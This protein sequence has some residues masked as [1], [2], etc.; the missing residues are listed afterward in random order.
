[1]FGLHQPAVSPTPP[2]LVM[3][4][5]N[6]KVYRT[7]PQPSPQRQELSA[8]TAASSAASL[9]PYCESGEDESSSHDSEAAPPCSWDMPSLGEASPP[10]QHSRPVLISGKVPAKAILERNFCS[11]TSIPTSGETANSSQYPK[12]S[13]TAVG[14]SVQIKKS[15]TSNLSMSLSDLTVKS[16]SEVKSLQPEDICCES[17]TSSVSH[18]KA[19]S[20]QDGGSQLMRLDMRNSSV[21]VAA[22]VTSAEVRQNVDEDVTGSSTTVNTS[23]PTSHGKHSAAWQVTDLLHHSPSV[24]IE[25]S[26]SSNS[27][28]NSTTD[29]TVSDIKQKLNYISSKCKGPFAHK[30]CCPDND[31]KLLKDESELSGSHIDS[32]TTHTESEGDNMTVRA[33]H[34][35]ERKNCDEEIQTILPRPESKNIGVS[36]VEEHNLKQYSRKREKKPKKLKKH[37]K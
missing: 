6:G 36:D 2:R 4:I 1:M 20:G 31:M 11:S 18:G 5:K 28:A 27:F 32:A 34:V 19:R 10:S 9:V 7:P 35:K 24:A 26:G 8:S 37:K 3:H 33:G 30:S 15:G 25:S 12:A 23:V 29:W 16:S 13:C 21:S 17:S 22:E 14:K